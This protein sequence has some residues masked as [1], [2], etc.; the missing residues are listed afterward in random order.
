[1]PTDVIVPDAHDLS[2]IFIIRV[3]YS[4]YYIPLTEQSDMINGAESSCAVKLVHLRVKEEEDIVRLYCE[5]EKMPKR[6]A[7]SQPSQAAK[8][9]EKDVPRAPQQGVYDG[10]LDMIV[11]KDALKC[12]SC[13]VCLHCYCAGIPIIK[14]F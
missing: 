4:L 9:S 7:R 13:N 8:K 2:S 1:M 12:S 14:P 5:F 3:R 6:P 10:C 11:E